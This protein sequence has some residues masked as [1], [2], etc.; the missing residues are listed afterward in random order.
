MCSGLSK[1]G[2]HSLIYLN[3]WFPDVDSLGRI[4]R[5]DLAGEGVSLGFDLEAS[6]PKT[7]SLSSISL[8]D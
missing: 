1:M 6:K 2:S 5:C 7:S 3:A 8:A 4:R